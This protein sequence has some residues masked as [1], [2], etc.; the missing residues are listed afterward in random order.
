[1]FI[2]CN[3]TMAEKPKVIRPFS[4]SNQFKSSF[5]KSVSVL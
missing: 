4:F 1:M 3:S 5:D 2:N